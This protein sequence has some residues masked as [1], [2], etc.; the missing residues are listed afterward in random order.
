MLN[1]IKIRAIKG[2]EDK[3]IEL[4]LY[5]NKPSILVAPNGFGKSSLAIAFA[6]FNNKRIILEEDNICE[7][8]TATEALIEVVAD[9]VS[10]TITSSQNNFSPDFSCFVINSSLYAESK[11]Q[12]MGGYMGHKA[13]LA[14]QDIELE[15]KVPGK[16]NVTYSIAANKKKFGINGKILPDISYLIK[17]V[18]LV[19][20][21]K[22]LRLEDFKK[23][24]TYLEPLRNIK[25]DI[26]NYNG[27]KDNIL[28]LINKDQVSRFDSIGCLFD[29]KETVKAY[30]KRKENTGELY[31]ECIQLVDFMSSDE[32]RAY[33][34]WCNY[35]ASKD[36]IEALIRDIDTTNSSDLKIEEQGRNPKKLVLKFPSAKRI[37]NGQRDILT[38]VAK[39]YCAKKELKK[40]NNIL[41]IDEIFDYLDDANLIAFQYFVIKFIEDYKKAEENLYCILLTHLDPVYFQHFCFSN[42]KLQIRYL[43]KSGTC[44]GEVLELMKKRDNSENIS[45]FLFHFHPPSETVEGHENTKWYQD[46]YD[47]VIN[48]YLKGLKYDPLKI[49]LAVRI[50]I[51]ELAYTKLEDEDSKSQFIDKHTTKNKLEF[52]GDK[53]IDYPE[54]WSLLGVIHNDYLHW[55][56]NRD[57]ETPLISKLSNIIVKHMIQTVFEGR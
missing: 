28:S 4:N 8:H 31:L 14:I 18:K 21:L 15:K 34:N 42:H 17:N 11:S 43:Q 49:C 54:T 7:G 55:R 25:N 37:S 1:S 22:A 41:I 23:K 12:Y 39:L 38:F 26:N 53:G 20:K 50:K 52:V 29:L 10:Y 13:K 47:E 3:K 51:E 33:A 44:S 46:L 19:D 36:Y 32:F 16:Q 30:S 56:D 27:S 9:K 48:K 35:K 40:K 45:K 5:P 6:S 24:R 2:I 57:Y